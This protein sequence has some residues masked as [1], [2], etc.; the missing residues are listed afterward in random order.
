LGLESIIGSVE[1]SH[2]DEI[3]GL[4]EHLEHS[5]EDIECL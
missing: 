1:S 5:N 3:T 2:G 4:E